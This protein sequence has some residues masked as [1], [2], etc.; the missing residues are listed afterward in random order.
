[1]RVILSDLVDHQTLCFH[2]VREFILG[3]IHDN[4][5]GA[6]SD[7]FGPIFVLSIAC[8]TIEKS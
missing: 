1:M 4:T 5:P 2:Q 6:A 8:E 3:V 7:F